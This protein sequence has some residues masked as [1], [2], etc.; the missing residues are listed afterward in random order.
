MLAIRTEKGFLDLPEGFT[1]DIEDTSPVFNDRGSQTVPLT[2]PATP[3]NLTL[4]GNPHRLDLRSRTLDGTRC[5]VLDGVYIRTGLLNID[6][7]SLVDGIELNIGF[8]NSMA[9][10]KWKD[11]KLADVEFPVEEYDSTETLLEHCQK[12]FEGKIQAPYAFFYVVVQEDYNE[13]EIEGGARPAVASGTADTDDRSGTAKARK[14]YIRGLNLFSMDADWIWHLRYGNV[15]M[16]YWHDNRELKVKEPLGYAI[17]P[18]LYAWFI[19][20]KIFEAGGF[21]LR[22]NPLKE[23]EELRRL[24]VLNNV[25]DGC[26]G[27]TLRLADFV[28]SCT[29]AEFM[30]ALYARFGL[31]YDI[32]SGTNEVTCVF[33]K[34]MFAG[35]LRDADMDLTGLE[36]DF[37]VITAAEPRQLVLSAGNDKFEVAKPTEETI[38]A[39]M[40]KEVRYISRGQ[41]E[42]EE[43]PDGVVKAYYG[44]PGK[45][46]RTEITYNRTLSRFEGVGYKEWNGN[47]NGTLGTGD[48]YLQVCYNYFSWNKNTEDI[49]AEE[50]TSEDVCVPVMFSK[51]VNEYLAP[52]FLLGYKNLYT[53][54]R[55]DADN[56]EIKEDEEEETPL[57]FCFSFMTEY[58]K[59]PF[60]N[61]APFDEAGR[62]AEAGLTLLWQLDDGL[63]ENFWKDY[64][65]FVRHADRQVEYKFRL[66]VDRL[67]QWQMLAYKRYGGQRFMADKLEYGLPAGNGYAIATV[68]LRSMTLI[69]PYDLEKEQGQVKLV[70]DSPY[71]TYK[72]EDYT[73]KWRDLEDYW[74][75]HG[76]SV[77]VSGWPLPQKDPLLNDV[78]DRL[79]QVVVKTY[80]IKYEVRKRIWGGWGDMIAKGEIACRVTFV[81]VY[82]PE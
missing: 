61:V 49:E 50:I 63:Y 66:P 57:A 68:R 31:V 7:V 37:P 79:G 12:V 70:I 30:Q 58:N 82:V 56:N 51:D 42:I 40:E 47:T 17:S 78:P 10:D 45:G 75:G 60:G 15:V 77:I 64:D 38:Q 34:D 11:R 76:G 25:A 5:A 2:I 41:A 80:A 48:N 4:L 9:Y 46:R 21:S 6:S 69:E 72:M 23:H 65:A 59:R 74:L 13:I 3:R 20:E 35:S 19:L 55:A 24:V 26:T 73:R 81:A 18:F 27:K 71:W 54:I 44:K 67:L 52:H 33:V 22:T 28:P 29:I 62:V 53:T 8:D 1:L 32:D 36:T 14:Y 43:L 16:T 39:Y